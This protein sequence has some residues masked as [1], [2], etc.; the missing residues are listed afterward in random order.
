MVESHKY[1]PFLLRLVLGLMFL[2]TGT[3]KIMN[4]VGNTIV[5]M[6]A[7][8][9]MAT[10]L[11]WIVALS[12]VVFGL[13]VLVGWK[14]KYTAWPLIVIIAVATLFFA[15]PGA[16]GNWL[17]VFFHLL[18]IASLVSLILTGP[19]AMSVKSR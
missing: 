12:E 5:P 9:P 1:A 14:V 18:T 3:G 8:W 17:G 6:L 7:G 4:G 16:N 15:I 10:F 2:Y 11:G 19:G 13:S